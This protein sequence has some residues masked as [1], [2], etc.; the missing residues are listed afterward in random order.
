MSILSSIKRNSIPALAYKA[1]CKPACR[2]AYAVAR[3]LPAQDTAVFVSMPDY[4]DNARVFCDYIRD[5]ERFGGV[6]IVWLV[7]SKAAEGAVRSEGLDCLRLRYGANGF[8]S[9]FFA[10]RARYVFF[11]HGFFP[12]Y[13]RIREDQTVVNL[14]HGC[15]YKYVA[16]THIPF[17]FALVPGE[18]FVD[19][20]AKS[21]SCDRD[22]IL[23]IGYPRYDRM[24]NPRMDAGE[25]RR[26]LYLPEGGKLVLWLPTFRKSTR[27]DYAEGDIEGELGLP[28]VRSLGELLE[29]DAKCSELGVCLVVKRHPSQVAY[30]IEK[31]A[32]R[33]TSI[34]FITQEDLSSAHVDLYELFA[35]SDALI[36]DYS[37]AA[38]D[39]LLLDRPLAYVL[40]DFDE[41]EKARGFCLEDVKQFMPGAHI[42]ETRGMA[43]FLAHVAGGEDEFALRRAKLSG[44]VH[45]IC[46]NYCERLVQRLLSC[47]VPCRADALAKSIGDEE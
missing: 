38:V 18:L 44:V 2:L 17:T 8:R 32:P 39:Y 12:S 21:F 35:A 47:D 41:Y 16:P 25:V 26:A 11:T 13:Y 27:V 29:L 43:G 33:L 30:A 24:L 6:R 7:G 1:L 22:K 46:D 45:N 42:L 19:V 3:L 37:S 10:G 9:A 15:G 5:D 20:K 31:V 14:W 34:R 4:A 36:S 23:P 40:D 28:L